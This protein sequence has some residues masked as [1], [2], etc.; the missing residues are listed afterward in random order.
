LAA[1]SGGAIFWFCPGPRSPWPLG[2]CGNFDP[3][4]VVGVG[5]Y[6]A[7]PVMLEAALVGIP[8]RVD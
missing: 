6:L 7:G 4:V 5:G 1:F 2:F 3:Q 8:T